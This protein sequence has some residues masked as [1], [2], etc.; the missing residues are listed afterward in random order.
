ME[1]FRRIF[2][3]MFFYVT[4]C[5]SAQEALLSAPEEYYDFLALTGITE[6]PYLN[7]RTLSD[8][9]WLSENSEIDIWKENKLGSTIK[10]SEKIFF[11]V[12]NIESFSSFNSATPYGQNDGLLWQGRG[13]N[14]SLT[15]GSRFETLGFELTFKPQFV[16]SENISFKLLPSATTS[17]YG[18]IWGYDLNSGADAP[19]RFGNNPIYEFS[20]G[21]S[22]IRYTWR[23]LT[24][25]FGTQSIWIGPGQIN[26]IIQSNNPAPYPKLDFGLRKSMITLFDWF[27]GYIESRLWIGKL[28]ESD[29]FDND[30]SNNSFFIS[31]LS[32][33]YAPS[34]LPGLTLSFCRTY[35][36][37]DE[38][39]IPYTI[40]SLLF[41]KLTR[42]GGEDIWDQRLTLS[43]DYLFPEIGFEV[44][45]EI[46]FN[47]NPGPNIEAYIKNFSHTLVYTNGLR[48]IININEK[49][50]F[51]GIFQ[52]ELSNLEMSPIYSQFL[53]TNSFYM[54]HQIKQGYTNQGQ[55]LGLGTGTGGN[56]QYIGFMLYYP[57]GA[58][59]I[60]INRYNPDNDFLFRF[61]TPSGG[62]PN[63][64]LYDRDFKTVL[65]IGIQ[66]QFFIIDRIRLNCGLAYIQLQNNTYGSS[67]DR[68]FAQSYRLEFGIGT[69]F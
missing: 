63:N 56:T 8:S 23:K 45:S 37:Q 12:F 48:K 68:E 34:F 2:F 44:Y 36:S 64:H 57:K 20:F 59:N 69:S 11:K 18:Y 50:N 3:L 38:I 67:S 53:W 31:G 15:G 62:Y 19:Q 6:R 9:Q 32:L 14:T 26:S 28:Y 46:G 39:E 65:A 22:E 42:N 4:I 27:A 58:T 54:H 7:Y 35:L 21:D 10:L 51:S 5:L 29:Y 43:F 55:W 40:S 1:Y 33:S 30:Q 16:F 60:Y 24:I 25:G 49:Y 52:F 47:D 66:T 41:F 61:T 13:W 17:P